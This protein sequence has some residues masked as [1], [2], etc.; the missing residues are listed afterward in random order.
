MCALVFT[1][2]T[3]RTQRERRELL[4]FLENFSAFS[5]RSLRLRGEKPTLYP[6]EVYYPELN[7]RGLLIM[8][9]EI[10]RTGLA[11]L[12]QLAC[13]LGASNAEVIS[14]SEISAEDDLANL[15][16]EPQCK[17]YGL[18]ASCPP[19]VSGPSGFRELLRNFKE[20]VVFKIEV[21]SEI[22]F[23]DERADIFRLLHEIAAGIEQSAVQ[24][25][26]RNS[27]AYAGGSCKRLFCQDQPLCQKLGEGGKC[28]HPDHARPSMSGY[29]I[30]VSK[31]MQ[32]AGWTMKKAARKPSPAMDSTGTVCGLVLIG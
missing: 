8:K 32:A 15:C 30:N 13:R 16:K 14:T 12:I 28:R 21:P 7:E 6:F 1:A 9:E 26:Y 19:Y 29:G 18:A 27:K 17:N 5:L 25:G 23:S 4:K 11:D 31:L 22:L 2:E 3:P 10:E 20:A 24:A